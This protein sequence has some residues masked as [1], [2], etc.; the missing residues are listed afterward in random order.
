MHRILLIEDDEPLR[1]MIRKV[2]ERAGYEV[3]EAPNGKIGLKLYSE[4][5]SELIVTDLIMPEKEG[6]ETIMEFR[7]L[8]AGVKIIAMSGGNRMNPKVNLAMAQ[9]FGAARTLA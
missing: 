6:L 8:A 1:K 2:L 5:P 4:Q 9:K 7:R 3:Q